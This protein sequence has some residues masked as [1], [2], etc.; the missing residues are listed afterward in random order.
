MTLS[1]ISIKK[2]VFAWML[3]IA[4]MIFGVIGLSRLGISQ[5]PDVDFPTV[6]VQITWE[7]AAPEIMES[8]VVDIVEDAVMSVEGIEE[9]TSTSAHGRA[10]V[11][12]D[13]EIDRDIDAALQDVQ[14]KIAQVQ[15]RLPNDIDPPVISKSNPEDQPIMW[16]G[17]SGYRPPRELS[18]LVRYK[19]RDQLRTSHPGVAEI[20]M[21]GFLER[22]VRVW[23]DARKLEAY[24]LTVDDVVAAIRREHL[25]VP[26][27]RIEGDQR[28]LSIRFEGEA[29]SLEQFG[30]IVVM[31]REGAQIRIKDVAVVEDGLEDVRR[32]ARSNGVP[33]QGMGIKKMRGANAVAVAKAVRAKVE[34]LKKTLP[35]DLDLFVSFD[36]T[37]FIEES[38][39]EVGFALG[40][41]VILTTLVC[42]L[43][44]GSFSS[45][46]NVVLAIP[47]SLLGTFAVMYFCGFTMNMIT[48]LALSLSVGIVVDDSIMV[49]E[50][51]YRHAEGGRSRR[52][53]AIFGAREITFAALAATMAIIAIFLPVAFMSGLIGKF[54]FQFG[55]VLSVAVMFSYLEAVTLT[56]ARCSQMLT[57][58]DRK[59]VIGRSMD[60]LFQGMSKI[61][62]RL[63]PFCLK[64]RYGVAA[65]ALGIFL[66]SLLLIQLLGKELAPVQDQSR[67]LVRLQAPVGT[68]ITLM[69]EITRQCEAVVA[70]HRE[71]KRYFCSV[72]GFGGGDVDTATM[73]VTLVPPG[74][75]AMTTEQFIGVV[76]K[77]LNVV[78]GVRANVQDL[79]RQDPSG[80]RNYPIEVTLKGPEW[81]TLAKTS[82]NVMARMKESPLFVDVDSNYRVGMPEVRIVPDPQRTASARVSMESIGETIGALMGGVRVA[83]FENQGRRYDVRLRL[84][85][86]QRLRPED[87]AP[88]LV[89]T[90]DGELTRLTDLVS[91]R[92]HSV[93]QS[94]TRRQRERAIT[95]TANVAMGASQADALEKA[96][97]IAQASATEG[98]QA[99]LTG[100]SQTF[101]ESFGS[102]LF[103]MIL[104]IV[105]A[106][107]ILASQ[108]NSFIHPVTILVA[109]PFSLSGALFALWAGNYTLNI[110][111][112]LGLLLLMGIVKKN[113][114]IL[115][116]YTNQRREDGMGYREA[117]LTA[118]PI[119]LRPIVMTTIST[120]VAAIPPALALGPG[121]EMRT[122]MALTIIG[123]MLLSTLLTLLVVP[124]IYAIFEDLRSILFRRRRDSSA[125]P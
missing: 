33:A 15:R 37:Q 67:F 77:E 14:A 43:F 1:D 110:F 10:T 30:A 21:G 25:E 119:R 34:E 79:S 122:P 116:D 85:R 24:R 105:I 42:W 83:K 52:D 65:A 107:M 64:W 46:I 8:E 36:V 94:I 121:G 97:A 41:S 86:E 125:T 28:E 111:S 18:D 68:S 117:L 96:L 11:T 108:F 59:G 124:S 61:Y 32:I 112:M 9:I 39:N 73:F 104:G 91:V 84:L 63:L 87:I 26:A 53:A 80:R 31:E 118:C 13:F 23:L 109:L 54:F 90:R 66:V 100:A 74:E 115:V 78:P 114:I 102:L 56:P 27:G 95:V 49:L 16:V 57:V 58:A 71:V 101:A 106:Y 35:P 22:N 113:S 89:R 76:R 120:I 3:M 51:I 62:A 4:T 17:L 44:L 38:V 29:L 93:L 72:G 75:R 47:T 69:N 2:P 98:Y 82:Q 81:E 6:T 50:N 88:L 103:A 123:G 12:I 70:A 20:M 55:I 7:G 5:F 99:E 48:L 60:G 19:L 92:E 40:F 45:T